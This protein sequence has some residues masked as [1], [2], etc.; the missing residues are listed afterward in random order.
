ML[1]RQICYISILEELIIGANQPA[2]SQSLA[3]SDKNAYL[4]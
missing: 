1:S 4:V 3:V 2:W